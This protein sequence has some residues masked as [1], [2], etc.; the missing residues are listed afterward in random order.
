VPPI[1]LTAPPVVSTQLAVLGTDPTKIVNAV[2]LVTNLTGLHDDQI[3]L[4]SNDAV[5]AFA[6]PQQRFQA[7]VTIYDG[8]VFELHCSIG[9]DMVKLSAVEQ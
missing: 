4:S 6:A 7:V 2:T 3:V 9:G 5:S 1:E 8:Q